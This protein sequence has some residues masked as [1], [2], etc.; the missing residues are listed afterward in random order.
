MGVL[1]DGHGQNY[2]NGHEG[3]ALNASYTDVAVKA[4]EYVRDTFVVNNSNGTLGWNGTV[5]VCSLNSTATYEY[6]IGQPIVYNSV[7]GSAAF[8]LASLEFEDLTKQSS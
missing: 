8:V 3:R 7:L 5:G 2:H 6:Y 1:K 4:Y